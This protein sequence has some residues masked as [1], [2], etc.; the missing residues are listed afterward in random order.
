MGQ[1][2]CLSDIIP[3]SDEEYQDLY[4]NA[5]SCSKCSEIYCML[6]SGHRGITIYILKSELCSRHLY[7]HFIEH[8]QISLVHDFEKVC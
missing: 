8:S 7:S 2:D 5:N 6:R 4:Q 3:I 1:E